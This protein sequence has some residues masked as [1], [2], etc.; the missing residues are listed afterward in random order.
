MGL[1]VGKCSMKSPDHFPNLQPL[2]TVLLP[3][4]ATGQG[5]PS[6]AVC[7]GRGHKCAMQK[8]LEVFKF[9]AR[10]TTPQPH[11]T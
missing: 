7:T 6:S 4:G 1:R 5:T 2:I 10:I 3:V 9:N 11:Y 8:L